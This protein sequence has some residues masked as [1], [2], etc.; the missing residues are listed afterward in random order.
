MK[1]PG[2]TQVSKPASK[3]ASKPVADADA[4][5]PAGIPDTEPERTPSQHAAKLAKKLTEYVQDLQRLPSLPVM[6]RESVEAA[7]EFFTLYPEYYWWDVLVI[8]VLGMKFGRETVP[9][10]QGVDPYWWSRHYAHKPN[11]IFGLAEKGM[12]QDD[13]ILC[14]IAMEVRHRTDSEHDINWAQAICGEELAA[15]KERLLN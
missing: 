1:N 13:L 2:N 15:A 7:I 4:E 10:E 11:K 3:P 9:P 5:S 14:I 8:C 6:N 12:R